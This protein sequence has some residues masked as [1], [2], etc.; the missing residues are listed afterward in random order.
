MKDIVRD[1]HL[2]LAAFARVIGIRV[3]PVPTRA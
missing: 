1:M 3:R 2:Q